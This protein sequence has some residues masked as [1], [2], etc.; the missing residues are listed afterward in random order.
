MRGGLDIQVVKW[1][2]ELRVAGRLDSRSSPAARNALHEHVDGAVGDLTVNLA[3][4]EIWDGAGLGVI[5]GTNR[6][7][8]HAGRRLVLTDVRPRELR[9]LRVARLPTTAVVRPALLPASC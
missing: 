1:G 8:R 3:E 7:A 6:R 2:V 5:V 4:T 9:M